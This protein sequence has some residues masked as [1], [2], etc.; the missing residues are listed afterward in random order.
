VIV[1]IDDTDIPDSRTLRSIMRKKE[2]GAT[3]TIK[4]IRHKKTMTVKGFLENE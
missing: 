2:P 4:L 1:K 3:I